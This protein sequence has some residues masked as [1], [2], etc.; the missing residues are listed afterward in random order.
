MAF[1][2]ATFPKSINGDVTC[3]GSSLPWGRK[4]NMKNFSAYQ[5]NLSIRNKCCNLARYHQYMRHDCITARRIWRRFSGNGRMC[6]SRFAITKMLASEIITP[7]RYTLVD[8]ARPHFVTP[9]ARERNTDIDDNT[10]SFE[11]IIDHIAA[12]AISSYQ[13]KSILQMKV[14]HLISIINAPP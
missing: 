5:K 10:I 1:W 9:F 6:W 3:D 7:R 11:I 13:P 4:R 12:L 2:R 14:K 8:A